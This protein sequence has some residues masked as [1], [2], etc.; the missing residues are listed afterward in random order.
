MTSESQAS[1][2]AGLPSSADATLEPGEGLPAATTEPQESLPVTTPHSKENL[3][4]TTPQQEEGL[5]ATTPPA[6]E[7]LPAS[8][9]Q[10]KESLRAT[11]PQAGGSSAAA[12]AQPG[13]GLPLSYKCSACRVHTPYLLMMV[14]HLKARHPHMGCFSCPYCK[15]SAPTSDGSTSYQPESFVTQKQLRSHIRKYHPDKTGRNEIALSAKAKQFVEAMVLPA[16]PECIRVGNRLVLEEDIHT[17]TYCSVKMTSLASVYEHLNDAHADLFEFVCPICQSF[18]SKDLEAIS[19][20][21]L[22]VHLSEVETDKVH[23][24]VPKNL[25]SVLKCISKGG[26]YIEKQ[27]DGTSTSASGAEANANSK[28]ASSAPPASASKSAADPPPSGDAPT[29]SV[30]PAAPPTEENSS[31]PLDLTSASQTVNI[32]APPA[33]SP[34]TT[35]VT[36]ITPPPAHMGVRSPVAVSGASPSKPAHVNISSSLF[37]TSSMSVPPHV[38]VSP[39]AGSSSAPVPGAAASSFL[40]PQQQ[41]S[42]SSGKNQQSVSPYPPSTA[43]NNKAGGRHAKTY[44]P[45]APKSLPVLNVPTIVPRPLPSGSVGVRQRVPSVGEPLSTITQPAASPVTRGPVISHTSAITSPSTSQL[46]QPTHHNVTLLTT[47]TSYDDLP[48]NEPNPDA[49]K[50]FNLQPTAPL[51]NSPAPLSS[52][53]S[54]SPSAV[55]ALPSPNTVP[56]VFPPVS[57]P[58]N[59]GYIQGP[60]VGFPAGLVISQALLPP[61]ASSYSFSQQQQALFRAAAPGGALL[62]NVPSSVDS[63]NKSNEA[64]SSGTSGLHGKQR[65]FKTSSSTFTPQQRAKSTSAQSANTLMLKEQQKRELLLLKQRLKQQKQAQNE[66]DLHAQIKEKQKQ[67]KMLQLQLL[68]QKRQQQQMAQR[69]QMFQRAMLNHQQQARLLAQQVAQTQNQS[70]PPFP[71]SPQ[72]WL[73]QQQQQQR[74]KLQ[75]QQQGLQR[76]KHT[77]Q[78]ISSPQ[79]PSDY[80][81]AAHNASNRP[82]PTPSSSSS[83]TAGT[84][85]S[86]SSAAS[87]ALS[88]PRPA[89]G[90][91]KRS[92]AMYHC[93]YCPTPV[94]LKALDV[95]SHIHQNHPGNPVVFKRVLP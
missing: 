46:P 91:H 10:P 47:A 62:P 72:A 9:P 50:I 87:S 51:V 78:E 74:Q 84:S 14:K 55:T 16:G 60:I 53:Q 2:Q 39:I 45:I 35:P 8:K 31:A 27:L 52:I 85:S 80:A 32:A 28:E 92:M 71:V 25:F 11:T 65:Q 86:S 90:V 36:V 67:F 37:D 58:L 15:I 34:A 19:S 57:T 26:K 93:P 75:Q 94:V 18:K 56:T 30:T 70:S 38:A 12:T 66:P 63:S 20:H 89:K 81:N 59:T 7:S 61:H 29:K 77:Q 1:A 82:C 44:T 69:Q 76:Q 3:L 6:G 73:Q 5:Q 17:C 68:Q 41:K 54:A 83:F 88:S 4:R 13:G 24:S 22:S 40:S 21:S 42:P 49:F 64:S 95:A 33:H 23:V 48:D 43:L 79:N